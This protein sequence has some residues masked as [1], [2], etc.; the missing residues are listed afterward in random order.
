MSREWRK[1]IIKR[2]IRKSFFGCQVSDN[3]DRGVTQQRL[4]TDYTKK[5][6]EV[7]VLL[8]LVFARC[9]PRLMPADVSPASNNIASINFLRRLS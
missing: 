1:A 5:K 9:T 2:K 7:Q 3:F 8:N 6:V 4:G